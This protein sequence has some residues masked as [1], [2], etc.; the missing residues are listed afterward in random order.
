[1]AWATQAFE[2]A[3]EVKPDYAEAWLELGETQYTKELGKTRYTKKDWGQAIASLKEATRLAPGDWRGWMV[4]GLSYTEAA[5][6]DD[7]ID[8]IQRAEKVAPDEKKPRMLTL[9]GNAYARKADREQ[10][11]RV[12]QQLKN[13]DPKE[14]EE[15]FKLY[16]VP[17]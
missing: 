3:I 5:S 8:A 1:L 13:I 6:Y 16:V 15:F 9:E 4:L 2:N 17:R 14:A 7:A 11:V 10:V 12:Y